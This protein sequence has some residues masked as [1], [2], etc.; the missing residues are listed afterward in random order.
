MGRDMD[1]SRDSDRDMCRNRDMD[2]DRGRDP[3]LGAEDESSK[4]SP[5]S[6]SR[7][8][9]KTSKF[10][11]IV[12]PGGSRGIAPIILILGTRLWLSGELYSPSALLPQK[13]FKSTTIYYVRIY[14]F[15]V[16]HPRGVGYNPVNKLPNCNFHR[17][18]TTPLRRINH[19]INEESTDS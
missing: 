7:Y 12:D 2:R 8:C 17:P 16:R 6:I 13:N 18:N 19:R 15:Q 1:R 11:S 9:F 4:F 3:V 10:S 14:P 5:K